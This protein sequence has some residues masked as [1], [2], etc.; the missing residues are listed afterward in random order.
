MPT[1]HGTAS[2]QFAENYRNQRDGKGPLTAIR[3]HDNLA[4][5]TSIVGFQNEGRGVGHGV[6]QDVVNVKL[7]LLQDQPFEQRLD[8]GVLVRV[9]VQD[10]VAAKDTVIH[11][12]DGTHFSLLRADMYS[13]EASVAILVDSLLHLDYAIQLA[14]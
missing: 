7:I 8:G 10:R 14:P 11:C 1:A 6:G 5:W 4:D 12:V 3:R 9:G 13:R 2:E